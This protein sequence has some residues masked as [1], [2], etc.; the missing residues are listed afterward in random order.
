[1]PL[2][3]SLIAAVAILAAAPFAYAEEG[4]IQSDQTGQIPKSELVD[5]YSVN[6]SA[7]NF[8]NGASTGDQALGSLLRGAYLKKLD[9][10]VNSVEGRTWF[11]VQDKGA[12]IGW[13]AAEYLDPVAD[14]LLAVE[15]AAKFLDGLGDPQIAGA[16]PAIDEIKAGFLFGAPI[17]D[18]GWNYAHNRGRLALEELPF[19]TETSY[20]ESVTG[21]DDVILAA[22]E[23]LIADGNNVIF[24]TSFGHMDAT[25]EAARR[26]PEIIFMHCSGYKT[27]RNAGTYFG[28]M[29]EARYLTGVLA[30]LMTETKVLGFVAAM[31]TPNVLMG[32][33]AFALG[34]QTMQP[35]VDVNVEWTGTW[36]GPDIETEK[37]EILL[38]RG[39]DVLTIEQDSPAVIQAAAKRGKFSIGYQSDMSLF[40][41]DYVLT[42]AVYTWG[43]VYQAIAQDIHNGRWQ[44]DNVWMTMAEGAVDLEGT[45]E[46]L[47]K[48]VTDMI[49][50]QKERIENGTFEVFTGPIQDQEGR[51]RLQGR[52]TMSEADLLSMDYLVR[53]VIAEMPESPDAPADAE[54][55]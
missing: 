45:I 46:S 55:D 52:E 28:R 51:I 54:T 34:A 35:D 26:H 8:R 18:A 30:G 20:I 1:M 10:T 9:E 53:G 38:D 49:A 5:T 12:K 47:P 19:V 4:W 40:A 48:P 22:I 3:A 16:F 2:L 21:D 33:N 17:G 44:N 11:Q 6:A 23:Q 50:D 15:G 31:P 13:V 32:I 39:A 25:M 14:R 42:S 36:Y 27:E 43:S 24:T 41:P 29:Y 7:L 37:A